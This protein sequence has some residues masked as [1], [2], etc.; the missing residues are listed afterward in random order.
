MLHPYVWNA[1]YMWI[2][3]NIVILMVVDMLECCLLDLYYSKKIVPWNIFE[4]SII[5]FIRQRCS[6]SND[7][8]YA[9]F[10]I[11]FHQTCFCL[12]LQWPMLIYMDVSN[13]LN[14]NKGTEFSIFIIIAF[15]CSYYFAPFDWNQ[16]VPNSSGRW[17]CSTRFPLLFQIECFRQ[18][19]Y[20]GDGGHRNARVTGRQFRFVIQ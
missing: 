17:T 14:I 4:A 2:T 11:C 10:K 13:Y 5:F 15:L 16:V 8:S 19:I 12:V 7:L 6:N 18:L 20:S 9:L 3:C 1:E